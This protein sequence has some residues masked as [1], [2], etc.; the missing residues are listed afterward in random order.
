MVNCKIL[1]INFGFIGF[2]G[3]KRA[4]VD[5]FG[6]VTCIEEYT[7]DLSVTKY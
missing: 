1:F 5:D 3:G 6:N 2:N 4:W 7:R